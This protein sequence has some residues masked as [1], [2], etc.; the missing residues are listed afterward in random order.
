MS[1]AP[2]NVHLSFVIPVCNEEGTISELFEQIKKSVEEAGEGPMEV[3]FVDDGSTDDSWKEIT[4]LYDK[5]PEEV[6]AL[7]FR[8]NFGKAAAL[9]EG[10]EE[11]CG[12]IVFTLDAD[13]QDDPMEIPRFL[14][15]ICEGYDLVSGWKKD[16]KDPLGKTVPSRFFNFMTRMVSGV[17]LHDFNCGFKA[18]RREVVKSITLYGE[19]HR[20]IPVL[21]N[22]EGFR[23]SEI[24][25]RHRPREQGV[26]K[27][28]WK[29]FL[30]GFLDLLTVVTTTR[31]LMRPAHLF[32]GLGILLGVL[33]GGILIYLTAGWF[34]GFRGIGA[35]PLFFF[36]ILFTLLS[37]QFLSLGLVSE[38]VLKTSNERNKRHLLRERKG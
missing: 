16:R 30:R 22:G 15:K 32:G 38:L 35:R 26:S 28:G 23:I 17:H 1:D 24:P 19:L 10:F 33:G 20:Y 12:E 29:R 25:V 7:A 21:A 8:R 31:Y 36:G 27:Y 2:K 11:A 3:I 13:L 37:A 18:Y 9:A 34:M 14:E 6:K 4:K 5:Y